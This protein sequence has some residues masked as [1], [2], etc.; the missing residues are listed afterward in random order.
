M[1]ETDSEKKHFLNL[2]LNLIIKFVAII[3]II[4]MAVYFIKPSANPEKLPD[5]R[6]NQKAVK[7]LIN[8]NNNLH[9]NLKTNVNN[10]TTNPNALSLYLTS[11]IAPEAVDL[12]KSSP[13][14]LPRIIVKAPENDLKKISLVKYSKF[15]ILPV[16]LELNFKQYDSDIWLLDTWKLNN[17]PAMSFGRDEVWQYAVKD[18]ES[19]PKMKKIFSSD[20]RISRKKS[21]IIINV[22]K[23]NNTKAEVEKFNSAISVCLNLHRELPEK[24]RMLQKL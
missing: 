15:Y 5:F 24:Q 8:F 18:F 6:I 1:D 9:S 12:Q 11:L 4:V 14:I 3:A 13:D 21:N 16:R 10:L 19:H 17:F 2:N 22:N 23:H 20:L 7:I